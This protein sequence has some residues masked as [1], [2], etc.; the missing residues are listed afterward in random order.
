MYK[1]EWQSSK[2][3]QAI[4]PGEDVEKMESSCTIGGNASWYSYYGEWYRDSLKTGNKT[5]IRP[6]NT[7]I[8]HKTLKERKWSCSVMSDSLWPHGL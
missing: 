1:S 3:L 6:N 7:T 8:G 2:N 4:N 5:A